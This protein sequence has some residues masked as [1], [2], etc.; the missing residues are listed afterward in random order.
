MAPQNDID[1]LDARRPLPILGGASQTLQILG[2]VPEISRGG[3]FPVSD[4]Y[5][6]RPVFNSYANVSGRDL[7]A[8]PADI[9]K[10]ISSSEKDLPKGSSTVLRG[11]VRTMNDSFIGLYLGLAFS[12][13]LVYL[14]MVVNFQSWIE[15]LIII[16]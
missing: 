15:P 6:I 5:N 2:N 12:M 9:Q 1:S 13:V 7:G 3:T 16:T 4:H 11:Q 10:L 8:V 14:L